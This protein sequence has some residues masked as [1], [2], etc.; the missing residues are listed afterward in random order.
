MELLRHTNPPSLSKPTGYTHVVQVI[1]G[2]T[3]YIAGQVAF[4][5]S[6]A[7]VGKGDF[8]AQT[9]QVME[10]LKAA[11]AAAGATFAN[12]VKVNTYVTDMSQIAALREIR[13]A[14]FGTNPP[15]STLVQVVGL[16]RPDL[17]IEIEAIAVVPE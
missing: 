7:L 1:Q 6:G 2:K 5:G 4:D 15:A 8:A 13:A 14:Y 16:A 11:L 9:R 12:V 3:V 17:M 10:N